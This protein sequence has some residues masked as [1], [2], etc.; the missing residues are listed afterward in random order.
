[1]PSPE[2]LAKAA[3]AEALALLL[4][5]GSTNLSKSSWIFNHVSK[6]AEKVKKRKMKTYIYW[7]HLQTDSCQLANRA[8]H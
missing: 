3:V 2:P 8:A 6:M 5:L 7:L 4:G 1:L